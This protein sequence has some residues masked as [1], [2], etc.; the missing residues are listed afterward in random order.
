METSPR[1][2]NMLFS[3]KDYLSWNNSNERWELIDGV[4]YDMSPAPTRKHQDI[5]RNLFKELVIYLEDKECTVYAA[6]FDVR[7]PTGF[8]TDEEIQTVVQPDISVFCDEEKLDDKGAIGAPD[9]IIEILSPSTAAKDLKEKFF[10]YESVG[11]KEYW[12]VDPSNETLTVY[13]LCKDN[14]YTRGVVYAGE[15]K[16]KVEIFEDLE[17]EMKDVFKNIHKKI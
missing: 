14:K 12:I 16:A 10:L 5:S 6:P 3:Y 13:I 4:A 8:Q 15:D 2:L 17:I 7:L 11:V 9:L 1:K